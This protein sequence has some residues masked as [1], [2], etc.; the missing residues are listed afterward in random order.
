V[1]SDDEQ[2]VQALVREIRTMLRN[3]PE[4]AP[5]LRER[6]RDGGNGLCVEC[7]IGVSSVP[8]PCAIRQLVEEARQHPEGWRPPS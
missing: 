3:N 8:F 2:K 1:A 5:K 7:S 6:H 4:Q